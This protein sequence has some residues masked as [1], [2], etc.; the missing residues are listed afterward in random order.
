MK[1][2][3]RVAVV[4]VKDVADAVRR[5]IDLLGGIEQYVRPDAQVLIKVNMFTSLSGESGKVT[6]PAVVL[7]VARMCHDCGA[8]V[9]VIE[10]NRVQ[11]D[12]LFRGYEEIYEI[13]HLVAL[14][15][16]AHTHKPLPGAKSFTCEVPWPDLIDACDLFINIPGLRTH[17]LTKMS[18]GMKNLMGLL[19]GNTTRL[20]HHH[21]LDGSICDLNAYRPSDLVITEAIYTLEGNFP[22]EGSPVKTD[23][24]TVANNVVAADLVAARLIGQDPSELFYLQEAISRGMGPALIDQIEMLG[25]A[26]EPI[27]RR[28]RIQPAPRIP[29]EHAGPYRLL[30]GDCCDSCLQA[31]V[32][33]L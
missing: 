27:A 19:P 10:R 18:N 31:L 26:I 28:V 23:L 3:Y 30:I 4:V 25:D 22:S 20:V 1:S 17:S 32:G 2:E 13:A 9:T 7:A 33:P 24:L 6:H 21:G 8:H 29:T 5:G 14:E 12:L 11:W 15:D 16:A